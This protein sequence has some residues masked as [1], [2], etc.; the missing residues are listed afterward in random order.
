MEEQVRKKKRRRRKKKNK[1]KKYLPH[2][3]ILIA[4]IL[5]AVIAIWRINV[6]N[7]GV[8]SDY[9]PNEDTSEFDIETEDYIVPLLDDAKKQ[10]VDDGVETVLILGNNPMA[11]NND[12]TGVADKIRSLTDAN[13][14]NAAIYGS[15]VAKKNLEFTENYL[16]DAFSFS[17]MCY[18]IAHDDFL[19]QRN[20]ADGIGDDGVIRE[21]IDELDNLDFK[22][23][24]TIII[25]YDGRDYELGYPSASIYDDEIPC[26]VAGSLHQG[27]QYLQVTMP[28]ARIIVSSPYYYFIEDPDKEHT[29]IPCTEAI[30]G[31]KG[32]DVDEFSYGNLGDYVISMKAIAVGDGVSFVDNYF[33]TITE[34]NYA[35]M[36]KDDNT[37]L[38][39]DGRDAIGERIVDFMKQ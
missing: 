6:W 35:T 32:G 14:V 4:V 3:L 12:G 10:Q 29:Y 31:Q 21:A 25:Q 8:E 27:I 19:L 22:T 39:S 18:C 28:Q 33:G 26:S 34:D 11:I 37:E 2:I 30:N 17:W 20:A 24:D 13:I 5:M 23:V 38:S 7:K 16:E 15:S 9:D 36:L 1:L